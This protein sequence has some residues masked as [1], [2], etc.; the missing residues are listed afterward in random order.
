M[1]ECEPY[2]RVVSGGKTLQGGKHMVTDYLVVCR[3]SALIMQIAYLGQVDSRYLPHKPQLEVVHL[4]AA[5]DRLVA[6][7][8]L[9]VLLVGLK[10][11][12]R[13]GP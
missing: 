7:V 10:E 5:L 2:E 1:N 11:V 6:V 4:A 9:S 13:V 3:N 12:R 8:E